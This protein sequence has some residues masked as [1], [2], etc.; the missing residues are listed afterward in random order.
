MWN[1]PFCKHRCHSYTSHEYCVAPSNLS[2]TS[3]QQSRTSLAATPVLHQHLILLSQQLLNL[4]WDQFYFG[5][6]LIA[7][8]Q[9][10]LNSIVKSLAPSWM[11][12]NYKVS[13][14]K[15]L[16]F[17]SLRKP[18]DMFKVLKLLFQKKQNNLRH[19]RLTKILGSLFWH[20]KLKLM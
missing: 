20:L 4:F 18:I 6:H 16:Y 9:Y 5:L 2:P 10:P 1:T 12:R 14:K 19:D 11:Q 7:E 15:L 13:P 8:L 17:Q 3:L